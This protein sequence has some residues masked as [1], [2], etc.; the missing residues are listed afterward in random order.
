M[1]NKK[2]M[3]M[4]AVAVL[5]VASSAS[6]QVIIAGD[7]PLSTPG[8]GTTTVDLSAF[9]VDQIFGSGARFGSKGGLVVSLRGESLGAGPL[10][11]V[12]TIVRRKRDVV[13]SGGRGTGPLEIMALRLVSERPVVINGKSYQ[14]RVFLSEFRSDLKPGSITYQMSNEDG[15]KFSS[16]FTVRTKLVFTDE[17]GNATTIDCGAVDCGTAGNMKMSATDA[18]FTLSGIPGGFDPVARGLKRLP[19]GLEVDGDGDGVAE[20][21]TKASSNLFIGII[22]ARQADF[23]GGTT[24]KEEQAANQRTANHSVA[25]PSNFSTQ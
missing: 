1:K 20:M 14:V 19:P 17:T 18:N 9:P 7:D 23:P 21:T 10:A 4:A 24:D 15:G 12:D 2:W 6:A 11:G 13:L 5:L 16:S 22:P 25:V 8:G 3:Y